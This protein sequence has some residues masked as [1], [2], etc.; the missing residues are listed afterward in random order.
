MLST[1]CF[2]MNLS[3]TQAAIVAI[4]DSM[5]GTCESR[6][7]LARNEM[8]KYHFCSLSKEA[9][10]C[11][12]VLYTIWSMNVAKSLNDENDKVSFDGFCKRH[13]CPDIDGLADVVSKPRLPQFLDLQPLQ[14]LTS[15]YSFLC[16]CMCLVLYSAHATFARYLVRPCCKGCLHG[17]LCLVPC[18]AHATLVFL[19][20][21]GS[22][23]RLLGNTPSCLRRLG[24]VRITSTTL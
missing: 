17:C 11:L 10:V 4:V 14:A 18:M 22:I 6:R 9:E 5:G 16:G 8:R 20:S 1:D 21:V 12:I 13:L 15:L 24:T 23:V 2:L 19:L 7:L 3:V